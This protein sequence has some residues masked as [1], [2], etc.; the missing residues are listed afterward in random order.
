MNSV[1]PKGYDREPTYD[2]ARWINVSPEVIT[3][4]DWLF[5]L[6]RPSRNPN[7]NHG[8]PEAAIEQIAQALEELT[9]LRDE[10]PMAEPGS[11]QDKID[12]AHAR[13]EAEGLAKTAAEMI[14]LPARMAAVETTVTRMNENLEELLRYI[15]FGGEKP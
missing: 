12:Q 2:H 7:V 11:D 10:K 15:H 8:I 3:R 13:R 14:G 1:S 9:Q 5:T 4:Y 6:A